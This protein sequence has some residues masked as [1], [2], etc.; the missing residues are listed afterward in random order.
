MNT[1]KTRERFHAIANFNSFDRL[2]IF[3]W[4]NWWN[5][6]IESWQKIGLPKKIQERYELCRYFDLDLYFQHQYQALRKGSPKP[7]SSG[8][9]IIKNM[10]DYEKIQPYLFQIENDFSK[11]RLNIVPQAKF[12]QAGDAVIW[13][14][15][16]GFFWLPR[17]L[18]GIENHL[19]AFYDQPELMHRINRENAEWIIKLIDKTC[20]IYRPDFI[21]IAEDM[22]YNNGPMLSKEFFNEFIKPYYD[23]IIPHLKERGIRVF[24]DSDGD[25]ADLVGWFEAIGVEGMLPLEVQAGVDV[26]QLRKQ[27]PN[28]LLLG[29]FNKMTMSKGEKT[30][31]SEF[32]RLLPVAQKSG[33]LISCDHQTPPEVSLENYHLYLNLFRKFANLAGQAS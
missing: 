28:L 16:N 23:I 21:T 12:Q 17:V 4:A 30:M 13:L 3:E 6:T 8:A 9:G 27:F 31:Q 26:I 32:K 7:E 15:V 11:S 1:M 18:L 22:S 25:I 33:F 10:D 19:Y 5:Q 2:P 24:V 29:G 20:E 14:S